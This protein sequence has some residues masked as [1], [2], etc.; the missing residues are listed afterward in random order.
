MAKVD[1]PIARVLCDAKMQKNLKGKIYK[2][3]I[4]PVMMYE[5][6]AWSVTR[7]RK[8]YWREQK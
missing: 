6:E 2:T 4:R 8:D 1:R 3:M 5:A 7:E